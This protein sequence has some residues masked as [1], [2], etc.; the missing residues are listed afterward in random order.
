MG[1]V[2]PPSP[3]GTVFPLLPARAAAGAPGWGWARLRGTG[4]GNQA[5]HLPPGVRAG[6][7]PLPAPDPGSYRAAA[8]AGRD[9]AAVGA[10]P[11]GLPSEGAEPR[12]GARS[13]LGTGRGCRLLRAASSRCPVPPPPPPRPP[14]RGP[15]RGPCERP[16]PPGR[17]RKA[18]LCGPFS[19]SPLTLIFRAQPLTAPIMRGPRLSPG[20]AEKGG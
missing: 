18:P 15:R 19:R 2:S 8:A 12:G 7:G 20:G 4:A 9:P 5:P 1:P 17:G 13:R 6:R 10:P 14:R 11:S 16:P 3:R